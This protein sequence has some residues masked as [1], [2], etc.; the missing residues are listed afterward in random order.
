MTHDSDNILQQLQN[1]RKLFAETAPTDSKIINDYAWVIAKCLHHNIEQIGSIECRWLLADYL[2][3]NTERPSQLH[4]A[5]LSAAIKVAKAYPEFRFAAFLQMWNIN[6][7]RPE[8]NERQKTNEGKSFPSLKE[9]AVK[10]LAHSVLLYPEYSSF[11]SLLISHGLSVLP[12]LVTRIKE[13]T[14]K[15]G[16]KYRFVTLVSPEGIEVESIAN[17][18][19]PS[20]LQPLPE[21]KRHYVN[22]GQLYNV[23][24]QS[25][26]TNVPDE[27]SLVLKEACLA[28][29]KPQD[30]F[31]VETGYI[32][33]LDTTHGHMHTYD[34]HSRHFVAPIQRFSRETAGNFVRFIPVIPQ[35]S[36]FKTAI[37]LTT[38][39]DS[40]EEVQSILR[41]IRITFI[42]KEKG[43][44]SWELLEKDHPITELLSPLQL[45]QGETSPSFTNGFL[46]LDDQLASSLTLSPYKA[47]IYLKRGKDRQK[48][49]HVAKLM[50]Q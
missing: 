50:N 26:A 8:D 16:R 7:F 25:K 49:P 47:L 14:G 36:K 15:D 20:P 37:I 24:L 4:S 12:M 13:A 11:P 5:I 23:L 32:E 9:R 30:L 40:A 21:G 35:A 33:S 39:P 34:Q 2:K 3:L 38:I 27:S 44:A 42:N 6:N 28:Q 29:Q 22:I 10:A 1:L 31:P 46:H 17:T 43:Y 18:L 19:L 48:R 41:D 45:S